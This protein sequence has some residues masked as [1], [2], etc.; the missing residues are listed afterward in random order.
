MDIAQQLSQK[1]PNLFDPLISAYQKSKPDGKVRQ[2][3][4]EMI[5]E[6]LGF[7]GDVIQ[8]H[9]DGY[10]PLHIAE[11][12]GVTE[13]EVKNILV[14]FDKRN[15]TSFNIQKVIYKS[16]EVNQLREKY[17]YLF[18][19]LIDLYLNTPKTDTD[20][21]NEIERLFRNLIDETSKSADA[22]KLHNEGFNGQDIGNQ[23]GVS[24]ERIRQIIKKYQGYYIVAGSKEWV[25]K[26]LEKLTGKQDDKRVFP[27]N[28]ELDNYHPKLAG[29]LREHF[30]TSKK[31]GELT[32]EDRYEIIRSFGFN[33][34]E[35]IKSQK[36][37][38]LER[39]IYVI[40]DLA[41]R[42]GKPDLMPMQLELK[43][44][45]SEGLGYAV[46]KF[47]GQSKIAQLA[48]LI[49]QG[50]TVGEDG[51]TYWTEERIRAFLYDVAE[52]EG[53]P[54]YMPTQQE[55]AKYYD[56]GGAIINIF[57]NSA[58]RNRPTL[59]W[60]EVAQKYGLKFDIEPIWYLRKL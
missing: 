31:F 51:R 38:T 54:D 25:L 53:H 27:P 21:Y 49:Y 34:E 3:Q 48:G 14:K 50:Q 24:R 22:I 15:I 30:T 19:P 41:K 39:L 42:I 9:I 60:F 18:D 20:K 47:G 6:L 16:S 10:D 40:K 11:H 35:E 32:Q 4:D 59:T 23:Y 17:S 7:T 13:D 43:E 52:K 29:S 36:K 8:M 46:Q 33:L 56:K 57:T 5:T 28:E 44:F 1:H 37:W 45:G 58:H 55:C 2:R 26:E 12:Y